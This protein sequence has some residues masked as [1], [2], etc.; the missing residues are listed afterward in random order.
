M[1]VSRSLNLVGVQ[2]SVGNGLMTR[3]KGSLE[4]I[5]SLLVVKTLIVIWS[6]VEADEERMFHV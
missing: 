5:K 6:W 3:F 2:R 4:S 1:E